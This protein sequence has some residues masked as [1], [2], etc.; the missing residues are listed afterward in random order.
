MA[1]WSRSC[2]SDLMIWLYAGLWPTWVYLGR[3]KTIWY[4]LKRV[5]GLSDIVFDTIFNT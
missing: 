5:S 1:K 3:K 2:P 4:H